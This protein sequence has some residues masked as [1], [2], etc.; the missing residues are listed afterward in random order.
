MDLIFILLWI[1]KGRVVVIGGRRGSRGWVGVKR[2]ITICSTN[3]FNIC[4]CIFASS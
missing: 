1:V 2:V 3:S 4:K